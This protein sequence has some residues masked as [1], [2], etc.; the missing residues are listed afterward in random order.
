MLED[1]DRPLN[2][3]GRKSAPV[4]AEWLARH[5]HIPDLILCSSSVRTRQTVSGMM[6]AIPDLPDPQ[7]DPGLYHAS[8]G[9]MLE[10]LQQVQ[11]EICTVMLVGHQPGLGA[12][13]R[14][15]SDGHESRHC[16]RAHE[17]FPTAAAAVF[18]VEADD[19]TRLDRGAARFI[20][21]AVPRELMDG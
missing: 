21:F 5:G 10:C 4:M 16:R 18:E 13:T 2:K 7:I 11:A 17:H 3:R 1:H 6:D 9:E 19:W 15:L 8:A 14:A 12:L 20:D